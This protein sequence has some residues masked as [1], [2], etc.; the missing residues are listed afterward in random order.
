MRLLRHVAICSLLALVPLYGQAGLGSI[1]GEVV[2]SSG[3]KLP[4]A[5]L[6]LV[7]ASTQIASTTVT[8]DQGL[9]NFPSVVVGNYALT[10]KAPG[11]KDKALSNLLVNAFQQLSVG[12]VTL[13]VGQGPTETVT[14]TAS[15]DLVKDSSVRSGT[16]QARQVADMPIAGRN[17]TTLLK[18]LP[19]ANAV[20]TTS[21]SIAFNGR[22]YTATGYADFRI[23]GKNPNQTQVNLDG[24][25]IVDQGSDAKTTVAPGVESIEE[26]SVLANNFQ[27]QYGY[28]AGAVVNIITKSG[29]NTFHGTVFD[30]LRN[31]DLNANSWSNNYLHL[32]RAKYRYNY[33]GGNL[34]GP[35]KKN[36]LFFFY[37][38]EN[39]VQSTPAPTALSRTPTDAERQGDFS[40]TFNSNGTR[41]TIYQPGSQ[42]SGSP[43]PFP[44]NVIP[45][46]LISP[47][48]AAILKIFP[49][50]NLANDPVNN[51]ALQ[52]Q[53]KQPR[54]SHT[55]KVDWEVANNTRL[56]VR[57]TD[58][59][60]TQT[61]RNLGD[62]SGNLAAATVNRP[63]PDRAAAG[64]ITHTF[65]PTLV[66]DALVGWSF[67]R[68]DWIPFDENSLT[69][70]A[71]GLSALPTTFK[72][73][74]DLL[75]AMTIGPYPAFGFG[76]IP[77]YSYTNEYQFSSNFS[78]SKG[79]HLIKFGMLHIRNYKNEID[80]S[81]PG[82]G[83]DKG[84]FDFTPS[85]S[86]F[87]TAYAPSNVLVG[88][89][90][91]FT[92]TAY[93]AHKDA[94]YTDT[95]FYIQ[96]TWKV[97][98]SLTFDYG[99]RIY[100]M[101]TQHELDP[102]ATNDAV[103]LPSRWDPAKAVRLYVPD[104]ANANLIIDPAHP[105]SPLPS[106]LTNILKYTIVPGSGD[107]L[108]GV[109][110]LGSPGVGLPGILDPKF[111]LFAPRGGF[112]WSPLGNDKTVIRGGFG[113]GYNRDNISQTMNAFENGLSPTAQVVQTNFDNLSSPTAVAPI[114]LRAFGARDEGSRAVPTVYDYSVSVQRQLPFEMI[115]D[116]GYV[117]NIQ[118][119]QPVQFNL[120]AVPLGTAFA[121]QFVTPGNAGYN[122]L[123]PVTAS[124]PGAL[125]G[126]NAEDASV[127]RPYPGSNSLTVNENAANVH[128]NAL[129]VTLGKRFGH[130]LSFSS[131]YTYG[132]TAGQIENL[133]L[134]SHNWKQYTGYVLA[135]D[136]SHVLTVNYTYDV[137]K[138]AHIIHFNNV[139]GREVFD[140]W[141][142]AHV[143]TYFSGA[144]YSPSFSVQQANTTTTVSLGNVF[145]GTP[146]LTPR[147]AVSAAV[148]SMGNGLY[149]NPPALGVPGIY[150]A[151]DGTGP[152]NFI[153]GLGSFTNDVS[154]VKRIR[155]TEK[156]GIE[157]RATA[158]NLFNSVRR[159]NT[160][161]SIQ[162]KANGATLA[163]GFS[164]INTPGQLAATQAAKTP[165]DPVSIF[166]AYRTGVGG[167]DLTTVQPMRILEI[168]LQFR[169]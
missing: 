149:F 45:K 74:N 116:V 95:D 86:P 108:N 75:P 92:Q 148:N 157:L 21:G 84:T 85:P 35:I 54:F 22:E 87:D 62:T 90:S 11:F 144:P 7:E 114:A 133:G 69:K 155:I 53:T 71:N 61:D 5:V 117:G 89:V 25:S 158:F 82:A 32:P 115:L 18:V 65:T 81:G 33:V 30:N 128:Y 121:P 151:A 105:N 60:G 1:T 153:D 146:D 145:L 78:W 42:F 106:T 162:Y 2:D 47:L 125:P 70:A 167:I 101:P 94:I 138:F 109:V 6:R 83:N 126:S 59:G 160:L 150:P 137:P 52:Y 48:G 127:M 10:I 15:Q 134:I 76:R 164:I 103:F 168:G 99:V 130:G 28:R 17:W 66:M 166:N 118:R 154:V 156:H 79:K 141:R 91:S 80:Q 107:P 131:A 27:A 122:F 13:E 96:D 112:A 161:S 39:F 14:V 34:G 9:F 165:N 147:P 26:V 104:P 100:H 23:N 143:M 36:K 4:H 38:Y 64:N 102:K 97:K 40:Q 129:Q 93:I 51:Y 113:W 110:A 140:G 163:N 77:A 120:N 46:S 44:G 123:G 88:A 132:R 50:P 29:T 111:L 57:F 98:S 12:Q 136:R 169:F 142:L 135:N 19:G 20:A 68:V 16:I 37:N 41:P 159:I 24:G 73:S 67:D 58:D 63:R 119:H 49:A 3:A 55:A 56:Y 152:R 31:E 72:A 139:L 8:N 124:N 43:I